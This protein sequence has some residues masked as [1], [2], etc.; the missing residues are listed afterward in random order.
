VLASRRTTR[1]THT[2]RQ[3]RAVV[4]HL[5]SVAEN[6][7]N[8]ALL[9]EQPDVRYEVPASAP[10]ILTNRRLPLDELEDQL[11]KSTAYQQTRRLLIRQPEMLRGR[12]ITQLH[13]GHVALLAASGALNGVFGEG[14]DRHMANWSPAR[15][16]H[17]SVQREEDGTVI[18]RKWSSF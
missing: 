6:A 18:N 2:D 9:G 12:P 15:M 3:L 4:E 5:E 1:Q 14:T 16:H 17:H 7:E 10:L 8:I 13:G 11:P